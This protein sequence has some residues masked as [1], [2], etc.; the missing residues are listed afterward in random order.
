MTAHICLAEVSLTSVQ[1]LLT[2]KMY[3]VSHKV[4]RN[5]CN[6]WICDLLEIHF[7]VTKKKK[8]KI[9]GATTVILKLSYLIRPSKRISFWEIHYEI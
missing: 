7:L 9:K 6:C 4:W 8:K 2:N 3:C 1:M 5:C